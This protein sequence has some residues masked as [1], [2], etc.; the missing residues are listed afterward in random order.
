MYSARTFSQMLSR[1]LD[2]F[3]RSS[4]ERNTRLAEKQSVSQT[5]KE[6]IYRLVQLARF[7]YLLIASLVEIIVA[8]YSV[9]AI[10]LTLPPSLINAAR[11]QLYKYLG[12]RR[13][14]KSFHASRG[15]WTTLVIVER[16]VPFSTLLR[17]DCSNLSMS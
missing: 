6:G 8:T 3:Q 2:P 7:N 16:F 17:A 12:L 5:P 4:T 11:I 1:Y 9:F 15:S 13:A 10:R 14:H